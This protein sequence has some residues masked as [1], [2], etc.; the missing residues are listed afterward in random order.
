MTH[1]NLIQNIIAGSYNLD[2]IDS[3]YS[4]PSSKSAS[5]FVKSHIY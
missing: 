1:L 3:I 2:L 5:L 4:L